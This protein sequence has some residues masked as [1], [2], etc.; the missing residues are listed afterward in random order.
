[1]PEGA[2][3]EFIGWVMEF[4]GMEGVNEWIADNK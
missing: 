3:P 2:F 1:M 4:Y